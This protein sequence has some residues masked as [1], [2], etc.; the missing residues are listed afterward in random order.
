MAR[1]K[2]LREV[3]TLGNTK[4]QDIFA[5]SDYWEAWELVG[6]NKRDPD[7]WQ[8]LAD[9][10]LSNCI[11]AVSRIISMELDMELM[12]E[13]R[14]HGTQN[15]DFLEELTRRVQNRQG[16]IIK[17]CLKK[18]QCKTEDWHIRSMLT[19][20]QCQWKAENG[21]PAFQQIKQIVKGD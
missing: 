15:V 1:K 10:Q 11:E 6:Q 16:E 7:S 4:K 18:G 12:R 9:G 8:F 5:Y 20:E 21:E 14:Q 17:E 3:E 19:K 2:S 13:R